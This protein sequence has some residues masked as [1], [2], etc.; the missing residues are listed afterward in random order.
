MGAPVNALFARRALLPEGWRRDVLLE[1]DAQ[2]DLAA[3]TPDAAAPAGAGQ[4]GYVIPGMVNLH[5]HAFQRAMGGL[6]ETAGQGP[7]SFWTWRELMYRF[8]SRITPGQ[9]EAIAAQLYAECLRHGYTAVCEFHYLHSAPDGAPYAPPA[10]TAL[11][12]AAAAAPTGIGLTMLP[13]LYAYAGFKDA[14]LTPEQKR[15]RS[16]PG[17]VLGIVEALAPWRGGQ[18]EGRRRAAFAARGLDRP[19]PRIGEG[20]AGRASAAHPHRRAAGR[21]GAMPGRDRAKAGRVPD[22][23]GR[24]SMRAGAWCMRPTWRR[25]RRRC[26]RPAAPSP[27]CARAP[28]RTSAMAC[29]R[30]KALCKPA[31]ASASAATAM[32]RR[33][34]WKNCAGSNTA[35]ACC[36]SAATSRPGMSSATSAPSCGARR[37]RA[38][39]RP[40]DAASA[41]WPRGMRADLL[42]LDDA[43]PNL[44]GVAEHEVL[45]RFLFCGNDNL[46]RDVLVGRAL[47]GARRT[48]SRPGRH[49]ATL[50]RRRA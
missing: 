19:D 49:R 13:V 39:P 20:A 30:W 31:G 1:W 33:V 9:I 2:G 24:A 4:A 43:H 17:Q 12:I 6:T 23:P 48:P 32:C 5:S 15:F 7:D 27:D 14:P 42:V 28:K 34:P 21:S 8:A 10:E 18:L 3:V 41:A 36:T 26:W 46:V 44:D 45:G 35:S 38:A 37:C 22:G 11:R 29:F 25:T 50:Y 40:P 47:G 16:D